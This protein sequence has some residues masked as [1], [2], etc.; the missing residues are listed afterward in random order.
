MRPHEE[1]VVAGQIYEALAKR[2][3]LYFLLERGLLH[4]EHPELRPWFD[5]DNRNLAALTC[6]ALAISD[7]RVREAV[8]ITLE[9]QANLAFGN[10]Y[11]VMRAYVNGVKAGILDRRNRRSL[12]DHPLRLNALWSPLTLPQRTGSS[13]KGNGDP[14]DREERARRFAQA[15][16]LGHADIGWT[17]K[18]QP[19]NADFACLLEHPEGDEAH[20]LVMEFSYDVAGEAFR[21]FQWQDA[22]LDELSTY[23]HRISLRSVFAQIHAEVAHESFD[24]AEDIADFLPAFTTRDKPLYKLCQASSYATTLAELLIN[25]GILTGETH[26]CAIAMTPNGIESI[27]ACITPTN[28]RDPRDPRYRMMR[29]LGKTYR[30]TEKKPEPDPTYLKD[31]TQRA[32]LRVLR[33][34]PVTLQAKM[35][36]IGDQLPT[37]GGAYQFRFEETT[38]DFHNPNDTFTVEEALAWVPTDARLDDYFAG[39]AK[40]AIR[41]ELIRIHDRRGNIT[42]RDLHASAIIAGLKRAQRGVINVLAL[43]GNPGIGKTTAVREYLSARQDGYLLFYVS[44]RVVINQDVTAKFA[45]HGDQ[46]SGIL[47]LTTNAFLIA[48]ARSW[49]KTQVESGKANDKCVE[50][51]VV[52]DG[53]PDLV[54]PETSILV[55]T[56]EEEME[57]TSRHAGTSYRVTPVNEYQ[58]KVRDRQNIGVLN[59]LANTS[60]DLL[61]LNPTVNRV[62]MTAAI[63][64]FKHVGSRNTITALD[65]LFKS[66]VDT[67]RGIAERAAFAQRIPTIVVMVDEIAGDGAGAPFVDAIANWLDEQ[68][69]GPFKPMSNGSPFTVV[70]IAADASLANDV[71]FDR[72]ITAGHQVPQKVLISRSRGQ[73]PFDLV[74][75]DVCIGHRKRPTL[76]VM[77]NSFPAKTLR[78]DYAVRLQRLKLVGKDGQPCGPREVYN[79]HGLNAVQDSAIAEITRALKSGARQVIYFTQNKRLLEKLA[80]ALVANTDLGL[81]D[82]EVRCLHSSV[83]NHERKQLADEAIRD[84]VRVFLMTSSGSRG[85]SFPKSDWIIVA[86]QRFAI[87]S[88]LMEV[89]QL[90]YR[91]RGTTTSGF[92]GD[93]LDRTLVF[94]IDDALF[95]ADDIDPR[96]WARKSLDLLTLLVMLRATV[97]SRIT[98][99][100][101]LTQALALVPVGSIGLDEITQTMTKP[102]RA[103]L[104]EAWVHRGASKCD[105]NTNALLSAALENVMR[106]FQNLDL[107]GRAPPGV[108]ATSYV[109]PYAR[110][111]SA[112]VGNVNGTSTLLTL[113]DGRERLI[114]DHVFFNGPLVFERWQE[115]SSVEDFLFQQDDPQIRKAIADV[116]WQLKRICS[117]KMTRFSKELR[118]AAKDLLALLSGT[119]G[120]RTT[121]HEVMKNVASSNLWVVVPAGHPIFVRESPEGRTFA[122]REEKAWHGILTNAFGWNNTSN[123]MPPIAKYWTFPFAAATTDANPAGLNLAFDDRYFA[124][125]TELNLLNMLLLG[126]PAGETTT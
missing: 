13:P 91:G 115:F 71:V 6:H 119:D 63:Q 20:L 79:Q 74:V 109:G 106:I 113:P 10:A 78:L 81:K 53:I 51:L 93:C 86:I 112:V 87:E 108:K 62:V 101:A 7:D 120:A 94:H 31:L 39:D 96:T 88:Q 19:A 98:G 29:K 14:E 4:K 1:A 122:L 58:A 34:L 85:I 54:R 60:R 30:D 25:R 59:A 100:A 36:V 70:L 123:A 107:Y 102:V 16:G 33:G 12:G 9:H 35:R 73:R 32:F 22:H 80:E 82:D 68:F 104:H 117:P 66:A 95:Y 42:L 28:V 64:G 5:R 56:P 47:T 99:D 3:I 46:P 21:D 37:P 2:G 77:T 11:T 111:L 52:A 97:F 118:K 41:H 61:A 75:N 49:H 69:I 45:R 103:F 48:S 72:Y 23:H 105:E 90:I 124:A 84:A 121:T 76:H 38:T 114:P 50:G 17:D 116:R 65:H 43:E 83:P 125:S 15:F 57:I 126:K 40:A 89:A 110:A 26:L 18:G 67:E 27:R 55:I 24:L 92:N 44:P 8:A